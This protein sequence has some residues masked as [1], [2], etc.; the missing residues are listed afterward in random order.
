MIEVN[1]ILDQIRDGVKSIFTKINCD[2]SV[3]LDILGGDSDVTNRN[4]MLYLGSVEQ[5]TNALLGVAYYVQT[6]VKNLI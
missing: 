1:K 3:I 4:V 6:K 5:R 2:D